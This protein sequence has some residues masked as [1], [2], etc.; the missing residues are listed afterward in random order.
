MPQ[1]IDLYADKKKGSKEPLTI[2]I[3]RKR[4][5][6]LKA[7]S[8]NETKRLGRKVSQAAIVQ[9]LLEKDKGFRQTVIL[10]TE[11]YASSK[12]NITASSETKVTK[13][14]SGDS[15]ADNTP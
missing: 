10:E 5:K 13:A 7:Y 3:D 9:T 12:E 2:A 11:A 15:S 8:D 14:I 4:K 1:W 6:R